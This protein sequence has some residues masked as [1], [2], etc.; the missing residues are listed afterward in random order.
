MRGKVLR[1]L[2]VEVLW[3]STFVPW[4]SLLLDLSIACSH[5]PAYNATD[6]QSIAANWTQSQ[7][8]AFSML[9]DSNQRTNSWQIVLRSIDPHL[10]M[11]LCMDHFPFG[12]G[13]TGPR[14]GCTC[15]QWV[16]KSCIHPLWHSW[17]QH[18]VAELIINTRLSPLHSIQSWSSPLC[19]QCAPQKIPQKCWKLSSSCHNILE[20]S[21]VFKLIN[22]TLRHNSHSPLLHCFCTFIYLVSSVQSKLRHTQLLF[23]SSFC[24][25]WV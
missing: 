22:F 16:V 24:L 25:H 1:P 19:H 15:W 18:P 7:P 21:L 8:L 6:Q 11:H 10:S 17:Y 3:T 5:L 13:I 2:K 23:S 12:P 4:P 20:I 14:L 9:W